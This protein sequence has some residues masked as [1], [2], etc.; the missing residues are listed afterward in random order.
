VV[1]CE[2]GAAAEAFAQALS[3]SIAK[4]PK[5][6]CTVLTTA[7][8]TAFARCGPTGAFASSSSSVTMVSAVRSEE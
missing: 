6:G 3:E 1:S 7:K 4:D 5:T 2:G 8:S